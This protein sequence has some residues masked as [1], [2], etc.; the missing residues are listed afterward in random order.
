MPSLLPLE[1]CLDSP[2]PVFPGRRVNKQLDPLLSPARQELAIAAVQLCRLVLGAKVAIPITR[3]HHHHIA[4]YDQTRGSDALVGEGHD[5]YG[6]AHAERDEHTCKGF[7]HER[8]V[9]PH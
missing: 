1:T 4:L 9:R 6:A 7:A 3:K 8:Q 5:I 2:W